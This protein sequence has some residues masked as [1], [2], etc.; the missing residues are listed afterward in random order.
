MRAIWHPQNDE[1]VAR[2]ISKFA[3][4][5]SGSRAIHTIDGR[6]GEQYRNSHRA[7]TRAI[8][9]A[10]SQETVARAHVLAPNTVRTAKDELWKCQKRCL[11]LGFEHSLVR[12][13]KYCACHEKWASGI[14][15]AAPAT[16]NHHHVPNP[17]IRQFT[18]LETFWPC[19]NAVQIH[20]I[21][22]LP[23]KMTSE[24]TSPKKCPVSCARRA[25]KT[26]R[27]KM[28]RRDNAATRH[29]RSSNHFLRVIPI[30]WYSIWIY[31]T[32]ILTFIDILSGTVSGIY[33]DIPSG[34][35][36]DILSDI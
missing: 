36:F 16:R 6:L 34:I 33:S 24:T 32:H 8:R 1:K 18:K 7:T 35:L 3:P 27:P 17:K 26:S 22:R 12:S 14:R 31:L 28:Y 9:H 20:Q 2:V 4:R 21:L 5:Y 15:S 30:N 13:T 10:Q 19:Q 11:D 23:R 29:G 25:K